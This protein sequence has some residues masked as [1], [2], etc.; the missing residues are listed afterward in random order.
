MCLH[1]ERSTVKRGARADIRNRTAALRF[2]V[3]KRASDVDAAR[4]QKLLF[5]IQVESRHSEAVTD[6]RSGNNFSRENKRPAK[7]A[8]GM[9]DVALGD[10]AANDRAADNFAV[11]NDR[12]NNDNFESEPRTKFFQ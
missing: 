9:A 5:R 12:R 1:G 8:A 10:F 3:E 7:Q 4:G 6:A 2:A 11:I